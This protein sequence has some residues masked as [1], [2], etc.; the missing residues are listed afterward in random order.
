MNVLPQ[1]YK[2]FPTP[3][4]K[5]GSRLYHFYLKRKYL[6]GKRP[7][8]P[9]ETSKARLR[10]SK[11]GFFEKYLSGDG[12]DIGFGGDLIVPNAKGFDFE[13]GDAQF[14][15][16]LKDELFDFVYSSHTLEHM[17][18]PRIALENWYRV[19]KKGGYLIIYIPHRDLYEKK[20]ALPSR[21]NP[22]H[23]H[24]FLVD[25]GEHP[26]TL[27]IIPLIK[28]NLSGYELIYAKECSEGHT[29]TDP[30]IHSDGEYSIEVVLRKLI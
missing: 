14:L 6:K 8:V 22:N 4:W 25:K 28:N 30:L 3:I 10:R 26:D 16:E 21:F 24:F 18:N 17:P 20:K 27:G 11:E 1:L 2:V 13:H 12:L 9:G 19:L 29:I 5:I 7:F 15:T 23:T